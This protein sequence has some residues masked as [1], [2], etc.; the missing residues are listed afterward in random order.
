M[1]KVSELYFLKIYLKVLKDNRANSKPVEWRSK[2][3]KTGL[4]C[5]G[6]RKNNVDNQAN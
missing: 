5:N 2:K 3:D 4:C 6:K 1:L